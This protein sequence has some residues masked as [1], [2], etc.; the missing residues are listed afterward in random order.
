MKW[1][2][3]WDPTVL[4]IGLL[5]LGSAVFVVRQRMEQHR[6]NDEGTSLPWQLCLERNGANSSMCDSL[7]RQRREF[8]N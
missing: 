2:R 6:L 7:R 5:L 3:G 8:Q 4:L 1:T